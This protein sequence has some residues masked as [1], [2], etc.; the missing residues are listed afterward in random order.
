M[1]L[2]GFHWH[3][4]HAL[5]ATTSCAH[6]HRNTH[7]MIMCAFQTLYQAQVGI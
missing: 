5:G 2:K 3:L 1:N 4:F 6:K 7:K